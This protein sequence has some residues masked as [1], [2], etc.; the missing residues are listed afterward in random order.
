LPR[1]RPR[2]GLGAR[3]WRPRPPFFLNPGPCVAPPLAR[4]ARPAWPR[5][6]AKAAW[7]AVRAAVAPRPA[8]RG[9]PRALPF[10]TAARPRH[11]RLDA[12]CPRQGARPTLRGGPA[13]PSPRRARPARPPPPRRARPCPGVL[14]PSPRSS[15]LRRGVAR[16]PLLAAPGVL[17]LVC[18]SARLGATLSSAS[19]RP[20]ALGPSVA[21]P[22]SWRPCPGAARGGPAP[23]AR[24]RGVPVARRGLRLACSCPGAAACVTLRSMPWL[25][26]CVVP[27]QRQT[28]SNRETRP[29]NTSRPKPVCVEAISRRGENVVYPS[30]STHARSPSSPS[31]CVRAACRSSRVVACDTQVVRALLRTSFSC[32]SRGVR[33][34]RAR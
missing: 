23:S 22:C 25:S 12:A 9:S 21:W 27:A 18:A 13:C 15:P 6:V 20:P 14:G 7:R 32:V 16:P 2:C 1:R 4:R 11:V 17:A 26:L 24:H 33:A 28:S 19:A 3:P 31:W 10:P 8:W 30:P 29:I 5:R 34:Y